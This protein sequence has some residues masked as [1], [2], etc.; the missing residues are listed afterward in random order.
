MH[1][2]GP[3]G[4]ANTPGALFGHITDFNPRRHTAQVGGGGG[5][6]NP[7]PGFFENNL[8][9]VRPIGTKLGIPNHLP[10]LHL[11][12]KFQV[13]T[14]YDLWPVT[15]FPRS[16]QAKFGFRRYRFNAWNLRT[17]VCL[18]VKWTCIGV[19]RW[20]PWFSLPLWP[21]RGQPRSSEIND[22]W[23]RHMSFFGFF[24]PQG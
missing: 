5:W 7:T 15:W 9:K 8:R 3:A 23:W 17:S 1:I 13:C 4:G 2:W 18:L 10:I 6:C 16:C 20:H 11:S 14:Y 21:F 12:W 24:V 19:G 22:L